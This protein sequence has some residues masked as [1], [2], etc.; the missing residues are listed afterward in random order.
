MMK[1]MT[2]S[3]E[4][5]QQ[6]RKIAEAQSLHE[7]LE[8]EYFCFLFEHLTGVQLGTGR[9]G[10]LNSC[11]ADGRWYIRIPKSEDLSQS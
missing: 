8:T 1:A 4:Q 9:A 3:L 2:R 5:L 11:I 7:V 10:N 6:S